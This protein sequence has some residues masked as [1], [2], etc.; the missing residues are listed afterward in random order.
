VFTEERRERILQ[1]LRVGNF[2]TTAA[3][4]AGVSDSVFYEWIGQGREDRASGIR[5]DYADFVDAVERAEA[6]AEATLVANVMAAAP[7]A[8]QAALQMLSMR[9]R[10]RWGAVQKVEV[11]GPGGGPVA[12][13]PVLGQI[14]DAVLDERIKALEQEMAPRLRVVGG[15]VTE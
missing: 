6:T 9:F 1:A 3:R 2:R 11:S 8:P 7:K 13:S 4:Y 5:S 14:P 12:I 10:D 15:D